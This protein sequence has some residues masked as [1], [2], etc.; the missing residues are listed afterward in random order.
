MTELSALK[1]YSVDFVVP[2]FIHFCQQKSSVAS[3]H[4]H[5]L[6]HKA[7][8]PTPSNP[9]TPFNDAVVTDS[10]VDFNAVKQANDAFHTLIESGEPLPSPA[11]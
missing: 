10:P 7:D 9:L 4:H 11:K 5:H 6:N 2:V 1:I 8:L 3:H